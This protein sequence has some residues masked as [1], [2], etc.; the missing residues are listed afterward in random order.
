MELI[1]ICR[2]CKSANIAVETVV[3]FCHQTGTDE[4]LTTLGE[5]TMMDPGA[6]KRALKEWAVIV[7]T[8]A[9]AKEVAE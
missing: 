3:E 6:L 8:D 4:T 9:E 1:E 5:I 2:R 7:K